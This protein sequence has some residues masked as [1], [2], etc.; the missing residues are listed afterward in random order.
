VDSAESRMASLGHDDPG[1][2]PFTAISAISETVTLSALQEAF[3]VR[4]G[5]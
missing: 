2:F 3:D 1:H 5:W 4:R